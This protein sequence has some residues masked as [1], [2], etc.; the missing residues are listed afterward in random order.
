MFLKVG[1]LT[2]FKKRVNDIKRMFPCLI[3]CSEVALYYSLL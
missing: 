3:K 2:L 1:F